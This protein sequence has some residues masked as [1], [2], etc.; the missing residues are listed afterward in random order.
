VTSQSTLFGAPSRIWV[1]RADGGAVL[2]LQGEIDTVTVQDFEADPGHDP[3]LDGQVVAVDGS[4]VTFFSSIGVRLL[5][6]MTEKARTGSGR[7]PIIN[8]PTRPL[9]RILELTGLQDV[10]EIVQA[11]A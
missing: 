2:H 6:R 5:L 7:R 3:T 11:D 1:E 8:R 4:E 9:M 10:F